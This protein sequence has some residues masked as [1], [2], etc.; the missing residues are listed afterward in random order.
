MDA[1]ALLAIPELLL[2]RLDFGWTFLL[3]LTRFTAFMTI[4]PGIGGGVSGVVV[5]FPAVVALS[6]VSFNRER[7]V[8]LPPDLVVAAAQVASE[9]LLGAVVA[10]IP[11]MIVSGAQLAGGL[12]TSAMGLNGAQL[13]DPTT[14][15]SL[16]DLA[17]IYGDLA[18]L[19]F[20][21]L[22]GHHVAIA[23]L[24]DI[25]ALIPPG[26]FLMN[27][28]SMAVFIMQTARIFQ[29]GCL[30]AAPVVAALLLTNF[31]LGVI[32][33]AVPTVNIFIMS[34]PL[35]IA[36]GLLLSILALPEVSVVLS[37]QFL[38]IEGVLAA[39][40]VPQ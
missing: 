21:F 22:G 9:V 36:V 38:E 33:K 23:Q 29:A 20:L 10:L 5:R 39:I 32:S 35:T 17:R 15:T 25:D 26:S 27:E 28:R 8:D 13:I 4:V 37:R 24:A 18:V 19:V 6:A 14:A 3:L 7:G 34:F 2:T 11:L 31:I 16:P 12:A 40:T 1:Q 30:T